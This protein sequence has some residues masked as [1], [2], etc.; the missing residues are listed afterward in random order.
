MLGSP[1]HDK[2]T[3][4]SPLRSP[5]PTNQRRI[6]LAEDAACQ[7]PAS[8]SLV[9]KIGTPSTLCMRPRTVL[10]QISSQP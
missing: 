4:N 3:Q 2:T 5:E 6:T 10:Y 1:T 7:P 9:G 8:Q